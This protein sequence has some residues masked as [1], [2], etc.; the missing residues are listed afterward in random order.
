[1]K[2]G[3][4]GRATSQTNQCEVTVSL[5]GGEGEEVPSK[6]SATR[7]R[8]DRQ[9]AP[10]AGA[11]KDQRLICIAHPSQRPILSRTRQT[12][13]LS[14]PENISSL[15]TIRMSELQ[16]PRIGSLARS[17][18]GRENTRKK[19]QI[20]HTLGNGPRS[21]PEGLG[22]LRLGAST[23]PQPRVSFPALTKLGWEA[24]DGMDYYILT[25]KNCGSS[26]Q[27]TKTVQ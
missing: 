20:S 6:T 2:A 5:Q 17:G 3:R 26:S 25:G 13:R 15:L 16:I 24:A 23:F 8:S 7:N 10:W 12:Q 21:H 19:I 27:W 22:H 11:P 4:E 14:N 1:M 18:T 9:V